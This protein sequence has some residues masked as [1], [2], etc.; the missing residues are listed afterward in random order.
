MVK[1]ILFFGLKC[2]Q[3]QSPGGISQKFPGKGGPCPQIPLDKESSNT[4]HPQLF[5]PSAAYGQA[6]LG[7]VMV[8]YDYNIFLVAAFDIYSPI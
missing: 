4:Q 7:I 6:I 1:L 2:P 8:L 5:Q 3:I